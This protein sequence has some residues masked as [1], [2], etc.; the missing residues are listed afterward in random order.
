ML[1]LGMLTAV[2][3]F[4][5]N[6]LGSIPLSPAATPTVGMPVVKPEPVVVEKLPPAEILPPPVE[7]PAT[8]TGAVRDLAAEAKLPV[9]LASKQPGVVPVRRQK[10]APRRDMPSPDAS[11]AA[12]LVSDDAPLLQQMPAEFQRALPPMTVTIHVYS[13][14]ESQRILFINNRQYHQGDLLPG[15]VRVVAIVPDGVVLSFQGQR[16][17]LSRPQ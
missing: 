4:W 1:L 10:V 15:G 13:E 8:D 9:R 11:P 17:K 6:T 5:H 12:P 3:I 2:L 7:N 14:A 16:F